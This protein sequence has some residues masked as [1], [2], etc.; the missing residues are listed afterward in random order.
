MALPALM[1]GALLSPV[2]IDSFANNVSDLQ[3]QLAAKSVYGAPIVIDNSA[4]MDLAIHTSGKLVASYSG[5]NCGSSFF[6]DRGRLDFVNLDGSKENVLSD[7][8]CPDKIDISPDGSIYMA[9][10]NG[11]LTIL[12]PGSS[13]PRR[14]FSEG[15][16]VSSPMSTALDG[17]GDWYIV[18]RRVE[19]EEQDATR[20]VVVP[21]GAKEV[22][23]IRSI[24][25]T[26]IFPL[27]WQ[28]TVMA[29]STFL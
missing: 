20:L 2:L 18:D 9:H 28:S 17:T 6:P 3:L 4:P 11:P 10:A 13:T 16:I 25:L 15:S 7:H 14:M 29:G 22:S 23:Q 21:N 27:G 24:R 26:A 19:A 8:G 5:S 1:C 12:D